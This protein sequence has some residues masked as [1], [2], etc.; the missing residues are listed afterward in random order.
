MAGTNEMFIKWLTYRSICKY[1]HTLGKDEVGKGVNKYT[2]IARF[3]NSLHKNDDIAN[4][5]YKH[6]DRSGG[7]QEI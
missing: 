1:D 5:F 2:I 6:V 3:N 7:N 4:A